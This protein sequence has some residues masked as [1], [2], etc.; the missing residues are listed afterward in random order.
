MLFSR[1][2]VRPSARKM[3]MDITAIGIEA[4]TVSPT[5]SARYTLD[6]PKTMPR[7]AP[8]MTARAVNS[9]RMVVA[10]TKGLCTT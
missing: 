7:I 2:E 6:A 4:E 10:G 3:E 1:I 8:T 9:G 5:R